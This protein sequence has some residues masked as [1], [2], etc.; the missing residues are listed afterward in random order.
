MIPTTLTIHFKGQPPLIIPFHEQFKRVLLEVSQSH[1]ELP[2][3]FSFFYV[4]SE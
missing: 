1:L 2:E 4:N 3:D